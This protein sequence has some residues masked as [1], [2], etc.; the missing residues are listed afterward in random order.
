MPT[1]ISPHGLLTLDETPGLQN[2]SSPLPE[3]SNDNDVTISTL[4]SAFSTRLGQLTTSTILGAASADNLFSVAADGQISN[5]SFVV[6]SGAALPVYGSGASGA[7]SGLS[8]VDGGAISLFA[9]QGSSLG[10]RMVLGVD[11]AGQTYS[12]SSWI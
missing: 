6:S 1:T 5:L 9:D 4:P 3:D 12:R 10:G 8:A 11:T 7:A 2:S